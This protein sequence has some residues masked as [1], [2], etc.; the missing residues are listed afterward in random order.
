M[1][2]QKKSQKE[3]I[4][5]LVLFMAIIT[6]WILGIVYFSKPADSETERSIKLG[7]WDT[8]EWQKLIEPSL[9][10]KDTRLAYD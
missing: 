3:F 5:L 9:A 2:A 7:T 1:R 6:P 8:P 4:K 10:D